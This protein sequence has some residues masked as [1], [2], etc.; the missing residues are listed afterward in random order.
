MNWINSSHIH[1]LAPRQMLEGMRTN[2]L[3]W[4]GQN[5]F[6]NWLNIVSTIPNCGRLFLEIHPFSPTSRCDIITSILASDSSLSAWLDAPVSS[7]SIIWEKT[8]SILRRWQKQIC[9]Q[10]GNLRSM[11]FMMGL[12]FDLF[13]QQN[14]LGDPSILFTLTPKDNIQELAE[15]I[16]DYPELHSAVLNFLSAIKKKTKL[17]ERVVQLNPITLGHIGYMASRQ[18]KN[19]I[20]PLRSCWRCD[21]IEHFYQILLISGIQ[22]DKSLLLNELIWLENI[23]EYINSFMLHLDNYDIFEADFSLEVNVVNSQMHLSEKRENAILQAII[24]LGFLSSE[25]KH[26]LMNFSNRYSLGN[27]QI[28]YCSLHHF[29]IKFSNSKIQEI[30]C[31]WLIRTVDIRPMP[32][33]KIRKDMPEVYV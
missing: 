4:F 3:P 20:L 6:E 18:N 11:C 15:E 24:N 14:N 9:S 5:D 7:S 10:K 16:S 33:N 27:D 19:D 26:V 21:D 28:F 25:Q 29:K 23:K 1:T 12:E 13:A 31:Y 22:F 8:S 2:L 17:Y 30:K 32:Q